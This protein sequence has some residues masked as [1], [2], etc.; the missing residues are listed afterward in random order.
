MLND[1]LNYHGIGTY[2]GNPSFHIEANISDSFHVS[3]ITNLLSIA[4]T[5]LFILRFIS[6]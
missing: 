3:C 4:Q 1:T 6:V 5:S 2:E